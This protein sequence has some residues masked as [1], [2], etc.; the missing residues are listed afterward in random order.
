MNN[1]DLSQDPRIIEYL[2]K[3][4]LYKK[5]NI[6]PPF[7]MEKEFGITDEEFENMSGKKIVTKNLLNTTNEFQIKHE[8]FKND[9][10]FA[11]L[12]KRIQRDKEATQQRYTSNLF[13]NRDY[14]LME[15]IKTENNQN[16]EMFLDEKPYMSD[17]YLNVSRE[18]NRV[19]KNTPSRI[20]YKSYHNRGPT[21]LEHNS[22][23]NPVI[24]DITNYDNKMNKNINNKLN[25]NNIS[26]DNN[27]EIENN[28]IKGLPEREQKFKSLGFA[29]STEYNYDYISKEI[30]NPDHIVM[31]FPQP[32]RS[33][34]NY[35]R[36]KPMKRDIY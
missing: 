31:P 25:I 18:S 28:I 23:I 7:N 35:I 33:L 5:N 22:D 12:Q 26:R 17:Y 10:R 14:N 6:E 3:K 27:Y 15:N 32:S 34:N 24:H 13:N 20:Q 29:S 4:E 11:K 36:A 21:N 30:Q 8:D 2:K 16:Q 1:Q 19:Y 9:P